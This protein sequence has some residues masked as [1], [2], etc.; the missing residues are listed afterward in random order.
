M[1]RLRSSGSERERII[2]RGEA[3]GQQVNHDAVGRVARAQGFPTFGQ[4]RQ[5]GQQVS[6]GEG[7]GIAFPLHLV[8]VNTGEAL[9]LEIV[10]APGIGVGQADFLQ[11]AISQMRE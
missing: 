9:D 7:T 2:H 8:G 3:V 5:K 11:A 10:N 6:E 1:G 4:I